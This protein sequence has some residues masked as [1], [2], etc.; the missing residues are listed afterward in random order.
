MDGARLN[1]VAEAFGST[2]KHISTNEFVHRSPR[3][4]NED[5]VMVCPCR[6]RLKGTRVGRRRRCCFD[7]S[8]E[9]HAMFTECLIG[10]CS[11]QSCSN[12]RFQRKQWVEVVV[13]DA[14]VKGYGLKTV[15]AVAKNTL[16]VEYCGEVINTAEQK[17]RMIEYA[18]ASRHFYLM[19]LSK[20]EFVDATLMGSVARFINHSCAPNCR[21][22]VWA[23][24]AE[25]RAGVF[26][27]AN[28]ADGEELTFNY[29]WLP[30]MKKTACYCGSP[31]CRGFIGIRTDADASGVAIPEGAFR[32]PTDPERKSGVGLIG[33]WVQVL[34]EGDG[35]LDLDGGAAS[36]VGGV[37]G[38]V[39]DTWERRRIRQQTRVLKIT[40]AGCWYTGRVT[41]YDPLTLKHT[42]RYVADGWIMDEE[43]LTH[44]PTEDG[45]TWRLLQQVRSRAEAR[46][47]AQKL[48]AQEP[49]PAA[50]A[51]ASSP[52]AA[53]AT[54]SS[55]AAA[56]AAVV[57]SVSASASTGPVSPA[58]YDDGFSSDDDDVIY[59]DDDVREAGKQKGGAAG[60]MASPEASSAKLKMRPREV[61]SAVI[62]RRRPSTAASNG[63]E[64]DDA[65]RQSF[66]AV[67]PSSGLAVVA[68]P[69]PPFSGFRGQSSS[70]QQLQQSAHYFVSPSVASN[71]HSAEQ[72]ALD[73]WRATEEKIA[74]E[75][76]REAQ[77]VR[78]RERCL[79]SSRSCSEWFLGEKAWAHCTG[80]FVYP[81]NG[82]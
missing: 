54:S 20:G 17:R 28:L 9:N 50:A 10:F 49:E 26:A 12:Q 46:E 18:K 59:Y 3:L 72:D 4:I 8:C 63:I 61:S 69:P 16:L 71:G 15:G 32:E 23:V 31:A 52:P 30:A 77:E 6:S 81:S 66:S 64:G 45:L 37:T 48:R 55:S 75:R 33:A 38:G 70:L 47:L 11:K 60:V 73:Q 35:G 80:A 58:G 78:S 53:A 51:N 42:I 74:E 24:G 41:A 39:K 14:G 25:S 2:V 82:A 13:F 1:L 56:A 44:A 43:D 62:P 67:S 7:D 36:S 29:G 79:I 21:V 65:G 19:A 27:D 40:D 68:P 5:D 34:W 57:S 22:E 76:R